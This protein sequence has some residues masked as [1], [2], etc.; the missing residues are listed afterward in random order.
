MIAKNTKQLI[1]IDGSSYLFRAYHALP[2]LTT[3]AGTPTGAVYGV[4]NMIKKLMHTHEHDYF[5]VVFDPKGKTVRHQLFPAY[6]ANRAVM[7]DELRVQIAPLFDVIKAMGVPLII[8]DGVEAD[9]VIGTLAV[10]AEKHGIKTLISTM[11]KDMAQLV[12]DKI[13]LINTMSDRVLDVAGV[14]EKFGVAPKQMIDYLA[15]MGDTS[16]NIPG[17]PKVGPKTA[18]M[19]LE[20]YKTLDHI[21]KHADDIPGKIGENL[22]AHL[23]DLALSRKLVTIDCD[24]KLNVTL[25]DLKI[26]TQQS[27]KLIELFSQLEFT[28]WLRE[29]NTDHSHSHSHYSC[30]QTEKKFSELLMTLK[31]SQS[32]A[33]DT[34][35]TDLDVMRAELVGISFCVKAGDA[36]Y[37]PFMHHDKDAKQLSRETVLVALKP[38]LQDHKKIII[39]QNLKFDYKML[40]NY[41]VEITAAMEDTLLESYVLNSTGSRHDLD[42]LAL[43]YLNH[44]TIKFEDVAGKGAKQITFDYVAIPV[45][46]NYAAEDADIALQLHHVLMA[47]IEKEQSCETVLRDIEWPLMPILANM[48]FHGVLIDCELL[49]KQSKE[50]E[51]RMS[52]L[53]NSVYQLAKKEFNLSS[54]KQLQEILFNEL[55]LP[56]I[57]KTPTGAPSTD[58]E[59][60]QELALD[61]ELPKYIVEYRQ[62]SKLKSTYADALPEQVN[63]KTHRVHTSYNQAVTSTGRLSSNNP[64][65]Q[66]IP[67]RSEEGRKIRQAFIAPKNM[68]IVSAD[69]SQ[70]ELRIMAHLSKDPGLLKAFEKKQD[71]HSAT[72]AEVFGVD[73]HDVTADMR[74]HAKAIN[75]GLLY[76]MSAFG[77]AKQLGVDRDQAQQYMNV[78]FTRYPNVKNYMESARQCAEKKGYVETLS[79]RRLFV[80]DIHASNKM[81]KMA[82]ERAAINAPLQGTAADIIKLAMICIN[83]KI[84]KGLTPKDEMRGKCERVTGVDTLVNEDYE[85]TFNEADRFSR[86]PLP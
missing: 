29:L 20:K 31:E 14:K 44:N 18:A 36:V 1:L 55:K 47:K 51:K 41:N 10:Y 3:S 63:P 86:K 27:K 37:I 5:A 62:L 17:I 33:L 7:P 23:N 72:A 30:I 49:K 43:K 8:Q 80:P 19:W 35:T 50:L 24:V 82:A 46:T 52:I 77:L 2:P 32:F 38:I 79:G 74:R 61:Y 59:V 65:L 78:Y 15:L 40:K 83:E 53:Q 60:M 21:V 26:T 9:D 4:I 34:E 12:N 73:I 6:K 64:N 76:G 71:I 22:R 25:S 67:I 84:N 45:A 13:T 54:P 42:T 69:Y 66:N 48:E 16:D 28:K 39:G 68:K 85:R 81:R 70:I 56:V 11:D 58:E 57:K 75:F